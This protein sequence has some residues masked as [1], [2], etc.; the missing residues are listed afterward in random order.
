MVAE[1]VTAAASAILYKRPVCR[2]FCS[3]CI[4]NTRG[5]HSINSRLVRVL[6]IFRHRSN[7]S[8]IATECT[9]RPKFVI[10]C[11]A[12]SSVDSMA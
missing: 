2:S 6:L 7:H 10:A 5:S 9:D 4:S 1:S 3:N 8:D 12:R 11:S